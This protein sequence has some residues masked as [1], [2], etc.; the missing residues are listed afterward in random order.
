MALSDRV[1][2]ARRFQ[3]SIRIDSDLG[4]TEA[5]DGFICTPSSEDVLLSMLSHIKETGQGAFTWTGPYGCGKSSLAVVFSALL[6]G[7]KKLR[8]IAS[9]IVGKKVAANVNETLPLGNNGWRVL[10]IVGRREQP[11]HLFGEALEHFGF[12]TNQTPNNWTDA[13]VLATINEVSQSEPQQFGGLIVFIDEMGKLLE[14]ASYENTD[15]NFFQNLAEAASRSKKRLII[16][17]IL[18]QSFSEYASRLSREMR[19]EWSKIQG[20]FADLPINSAGE[21]QIELISRAIESDYH[22][23]DPKPHSTSIANIILHNKPAVSKQIALT[24]EECWPLHPVVAC[25]LGPISRRRFGQNQRSIFGFLNSA[26]PRGF[27]DF[28]RNAPDNKL[29]EPYK[30]WDYLRINLEPTILASP[31]GHRWAIAAEAIERCEVIGG[32]NTDIK[33]L[34]TIALIDLFKERSGISA[35]IELLRCCFDGI[36]HKEVQQSIDQLKM[37]SFIIYKKFSHSFSIY[38]GSDFDI[39]QAVE[40]ALEHT[41]LID[42]NALRNLAG[43]QPILAKRYYHKT[44]ALW[45]FDVD[46]M[47]VK[48]LADATSEYKPRQGTIGQ[49]ILA[50][51]TEGETKQ[52]AEELCRESATKDHQWDVIVG[53]SPRTWGITSLAQELLATEKVLNERVELAGDAVARREVCARLASLQGLLEAELNNAFAK[54]TWYLKHYETK[55]RCHAELNQIASELADNRFHKSPL[56]HNELLNRIKPSASAISAQN[57]LLRC[58]VMNEGKERLGIQ[59]YPSE[60]GL[61]ASL[62]EATGLYQQ[63]EHGWS[64]VSPLVNDSHNLYPLW[65]SARELLSTNSHRSV[66]VSELFDLWSKGEFGVKNGLLPVLAVAFVLSERP[67]LAFYREG[68]FQPKFKDLDVEYLAKDASDIQLRWMNLSDMSRRLLSEM[69]EIVRQLDCT[70]DLKNLEPIDVARGLIS[71]FVNLHP[72]VKRT[73]QQLSTNAIRIRTL[74]NH[75][76]DPNK[77]IFDDIPGM[78]GI[79]TKDISNSDLNVVITSIREGLE[80]LVQAYP[81]LLFKLRDILF[82]ELQVPNALPNALTDLRCRA[83]NIKKVT[84]DFRLES[85]IGRLSQFTGSIEDIEGIASLTLNK[86]ARDWIDSDIDKASLELADLAQKFIRAESYAR[87]KGRTDKRHAIAVVVGIGGRPTPIRKEFHITDADKKS[88][89]SV[90]YKIKA[91]LKQSGKLDDNIVLAALAELSA[92]YMQPE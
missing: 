89:A 69:A 26:E 36:A 48:D 9:N 4:A 71:V 33:V 28:I 40:E 80:E 81:A 7:D 78:F 47:P 59:G 73:L 54:A 75:A 83:E 15:I 44:G 56:I 76:N 60:G 22:P 5:L 91:A 42:F 53:I 72:W 20:R 66:S 35:S 50:I 14:G 55:E 17:G 45:W 85:L 23:V 10:P 46:V 25:L 70:K 19:D 12:K 6:G 51:P 30:L 64:F 2:I 32:S 1:H 39:D 90:L 57:S 52:V 13:S 87:V 31:D 77:F 37:W 24:L 68:V 67:N 3:R 16:V 29:Y 88:V 49:F 61:F 74:F 65:E 34:K 41:M 62:I 82:A 79:H 92:S 84:G 38:A 18:H 63:T 86:P 8:N 21:E 43:I 58:M 11:A 27:Q